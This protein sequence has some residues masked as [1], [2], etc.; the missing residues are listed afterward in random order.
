[1]KVWIVKGFC[2]YTGRRK[3]IEVTAS[4]SKEAR[5]IAHSELTYPRVL[6]AK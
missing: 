5:A 1:M 4:S 3:T 2:L 6:G